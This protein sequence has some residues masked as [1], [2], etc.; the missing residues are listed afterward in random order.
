MIKWVRTKITYYT[1][2]NRKSI[3]FLSLL[4]F[5]K[6]ISSI[7]ISLIPKL[8]QS[9]SLSILTSLKIC[10][11]SIVHPSMSSTSRNFTKY[12]MI[13]TIHSPLSRLSSESWLEGTLLWSG[14]TNTVETGLIRPSSFPSAWRKDSSTSNTEKARFI[15]ISNLDHHSEA[16][17]NIGTS[18]Y[19]KKTDC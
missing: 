2:Y 9:L 15:M 1:N 4:P 16:C 7:L 19:S 13:R 10:A 14:T 17:L 6:S 12:V 8:M 18:K 3:F 11:C 5:V